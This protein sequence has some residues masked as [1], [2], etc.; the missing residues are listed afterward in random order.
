M[1]K[2]VAASLS[3]LAATAGQHVTCSHVCLCGLIVAMAWICGYTKAC[4]QPASGLLL[5]QQAGCAQYV[6]A[7]AEAAGSWLVTMA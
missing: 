2:L 4:A 7:D 1:Q 6:E 5:L 3:L